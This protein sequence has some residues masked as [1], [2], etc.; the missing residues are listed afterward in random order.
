MQLTKTWLLLL[1]CQEVL[2]EC[3]QQRQH[4]WAKAISK[5]AQN[6]RLTAPGGAAPS[7]S[8]SCF[9]QFLDLSILINTEVFLSLVTMLFSQGHRKAHAI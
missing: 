8:E 2:F 7:Y 4:L 5:Q 9:G 6:D 3:Q 1:K